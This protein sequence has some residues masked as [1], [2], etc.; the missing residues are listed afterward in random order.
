M[1]EVCVS[2]NLDVS[3]GELS[4]QPWTV[5]RHVFDSSYS[6]V[7]N[8]DYGAQTSLPGKLMID[9]GIQTW[10]NTSPL[11]AQVLMRVNRGARYFAVSAP[12]V[13]QIRDRWTTAIDGDPREPDTTNQYQG[14]SGGGIDMSTTTTTL[15]YAGLLWNWDDAMIT[16]DWFGPV[17]PGG[18][19]SFW[20]RCT[21]WT[22]PPWSNNAN[23]GI[24]FHEATVDPVRFQL[25][26]FPTQDQAVMG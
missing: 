5:P 11:D 15:P 3:T 1:A 10:T 18:T 22:P 23:G 8:G 9:S 2:R 21:L 24:P 4:V 25:M 20:Y 13:V 19:F 12:N 17:P 14:A 16:E 26:A 7:G 6:S